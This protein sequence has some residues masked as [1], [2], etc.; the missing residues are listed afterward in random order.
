MSLDGKNRKEVLHPK[1]LKFQN[2]MS[3]HSI[4]LCWGRRVVKINFK[5]G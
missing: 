5:I 4:L 3:K 1:N 2:A